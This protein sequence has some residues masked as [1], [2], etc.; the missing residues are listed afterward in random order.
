MT[1]LSF[2]SLTSK[3]TPV[4]G[5]TLF[6]NDTLQSKLTILA[7]DIEGMLQQFAG[8]LKAEIGNVNE[9]VLTVNEN[10]I[11]GLACLRENDKKIMTKLDQLKE[12]TLADSLS[13]GMESNEEVLRLREELANKEQIIRQKDELIA[14]LMKQLNERK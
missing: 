9:N 3:K 7:G 11:A 1:G 14:L 2:T 8:D 5:E 10:L 4:N 6:A 13:F 12:G